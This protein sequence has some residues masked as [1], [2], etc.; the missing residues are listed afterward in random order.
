MVKVQ[1]VYRTGKATEH[2]YRSAIESLFTAL[3]VT[4]LNEPKRVKCGAPDFIISQGE[5]VIGHVEV[6]DL[7][8]NIRSIKDAANRSQQ[9]RYR[10]A[11]PNLI[12]TNCRDWDFYRDGRLVASVTVAHW[13]MGL[14]PKP[15]QYTALEDLL[16]NF[17]VQYPQIIVS[18]RHLAE[19]MAGKAKLIK[20]VLSKTLA[21]DQALKSELFLQYQAFQDNLIHGIT[22]EDFADIYAETIA[23]GMFAARLHDTSLHRFNRK[24]ALELLPKSNPF[25]RSLFTYIAGYDL[26]ERIAWIID[27]L[28]RMFNACD[29]VRLME[30]FGKLSGQQDPFLHFYE[31][32]LTTYNSAKRKSCGV[33]Y[34]PE[35]VVNFIIRAIDGVLQTE[36]GLTD[37]LADTSKISVAL[38]S[39]QTDG[40]G[41]TITHY[42]EVHRVQI[43]DPAA[44]TGTFL[45]QV[46]KQIAPKVQDVAPSLWS[47]YIEQDLIPRLHGFELLMASY[48]MCHIKLDMILTEMGY[49]PTD[50]P[51]RLSVYLTNSL[52]EGEPVNQT[53]PFIQWLSREAQGANAIKRH[54]PIMCVI[55]NP[56][57]LG[58]SGESKG[59]LGDLMK[60]Y[61][62]EPGGTVK[63]KE[64][65]IKWLNDL[66]VKFIRMS[67]FL[68]EKNGEGVLGFITNHGY[69]D[70][71][72]FRGMRWHLLKTFDRI[73]VLD[74]HGN[75]KKKEVTL[76]GKPDE[77]VFDI[78]QGVAIMIAVK[79]QDSGPDLAEVMHGDLRG[80]RESK[81]G[82]LA[83]GML[84]KVL[85]K[86]LATPAPQYPFVPRNF[87]ALKDYETGFAINQFMAVNSV[88]IVTARDSL[89]TDKDK[90]C[91]WERVQDF[92][93]LETEKAREKYKLGK[94]VR[95]C[96]V[97]WAQDDVRK[98]LSMDRITAIAYRPFDHRW[99]LYTGKSRGFI[100]RS[101]H[102][103]MRHLIGHD[104]LAL[105]VGRA[106]QVIGSPIWDIVFCTNTAP[107]LN[108]YYR[109]GNCCFPLYLYPDEQDLYQTR[110]VNFHADLYDR[111]QKLAHHPSH[112]TPDE[113]VV[114][115]YI[116]G[117]LHCPA[118]RN[119]Y[120]EFLKTDFPRI[121]WPK[122]P[123]LFWAIS[124][125]GTML[126][127]L[128]LMDPVAIGPTPYPLI[129][130][131]D[132]LVEKPRFANG[133]IWIN[134][135]QFFENVSQIAWE[136]SIGG[137]R[138]AQKWLKDRK[139]QVLS[140]QEVKHYQ[141]ILKI[142]MET[143]RIMATIEM[144][145]P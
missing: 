78:Q 58:E 139:G 97:S 73:W 14:Q 132:H 2:S 61:K 102:E 42:K 67:S 90:Q 123:N 118:Y 112:G 43:L 125:K 129:G 39:G 114:F 119:A 5:T 21:E 100:C 26:D 143:D 95:D 32:F 126:R 113:V 98:N 107:D 65:N 96:K 101:R 115:D 31:T 138:P 22:P 1:A 57:Y 34:T 53:L 131:G 141:R 136:F 59:W 70:N 81:Y 130:N 110:R 104:N 74:L 10:A 75:A 17:V 8:V 140:F 3:H 137:Y 18:P 84:D 122:T 121:P 109:G 19:N 48:A 24:Q 91:L 60:D 55:G 86:P 7:P 25:L 28:A 69:L 124:A 71:P 4:A 11:L 33:W 120:G 93:S 63:L 106:G 127:K 88:G 79:K 76:E 35:P 77:N 128:H 134:E 38:D 52:E 94:D 37:G 30:D 66:Y 44:G 133:R 45:A 111:L 15:D 41:K 6:K 50:K 80:K 40:R 62:K 51:P 135:A 145:F 36:F 103:I 64:R 16:R 116:Y 83:A 23:Y 9:E 108:L 89:T 13:S 85:F 99:T 87:T 12:Y 29:M 72:T 68:I 27:D 46:I 82:V 105:C 92:A 142:L 117:V 144:D 54:M 49:K 47:Q 56:P 20:D